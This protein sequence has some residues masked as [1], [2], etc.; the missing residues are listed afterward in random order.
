MMCWFFSFTKISIPQNWNGKSI[1]AKHD[2]YGQQP[3]V[4]TGK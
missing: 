3:D 2:S 4:T 1:F